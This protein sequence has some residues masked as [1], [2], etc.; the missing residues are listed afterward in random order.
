M[1]KNL[2][3]LSGILAKM[4]LR[5]T[6]EKKPVCH[7]YLSQ[8]DKKND[9]V[10]SFIC[11]SENDL[12]ERISKIEVG[13]N[14]TVFGRLDTKR[15]KDANGNAESFTEVY[16]TEAYTT[17]QC[18]NKALIAGRFS[19]DHKYFTATENKKSVLRN[20]IAVSVKTGTS[21]TEHTEFINCTFFDR[22]ADFVSKYFRKG[23]AIWVEGRLSL[24]RFTD[25]DG[26]ART[27]WKV[28][29]SRAEFLEAKKQEK[30]D[31]MP[32]DGMPAEKPDEGQKPTADGFVP[33]PGGW[34]NL[35]VD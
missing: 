1:Q 19:Q 12:A 14:I 3:I 17:D 11:R 33:I 15:Y 34:G 9:S 4:E 8:Q 25:R 35:P 20:S 22:V 31:A 16:V 2:L 21:E 26:N 24:E 13:S 23:V 10:T 27:A 5:Y 30:S 29:A 7:F 32:V 18:I 28:N 6:Q